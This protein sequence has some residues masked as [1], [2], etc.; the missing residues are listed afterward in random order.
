MGRFE[1]KYRIDNL[2]LEEVRQVLRMHPVA[3]R[4][5]HADRRINNIYFDK[6]VRKIRGRFGTT[7]IRTTDSRKMIAEMANSNKQFI[8]GL[9]SDQS[10]MLN[11]A[12]HWA[13]FMGIEVPIHVG[14]EEMSKQHNLV[15]IFMKVKKLKRGHYAA[16]FELITENPREVPDYQISE[17]FMNRLEESIK[18]AP[19]F[20]FWTHKRFKHRGKKPEKTV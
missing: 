5:Q 18:E 14:A 3:F 20:Y 16:T 9:A 13:K 19:E 11:R 7:L 6:L 17:I 8:L 2:T 1:R 12:R 4:K 10:P 15:P